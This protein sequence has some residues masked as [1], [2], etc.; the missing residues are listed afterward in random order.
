LTLLRS[1]VKTQAS[2]VCTKLHSNSSSHIRG[3]EAA[4]NTLKKPVKM[5]KNFAA[6]WEVPV[7]ASNS[8]RVTT[9]WSGRGARKYRPAVSSVSFARA[10]VM[11]CFC[12]IVKAMSG[13][14]QTNAMASFRPFGLTSICRVAAL[15]TS[16]AGRPD[17]FAR[18]VSRPSKRMRVDRKA[19]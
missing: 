15:K 12:E 6:R 2:K 9:H 3:W 11:L 13:C 19:V 4:V 18:T 14:L 8:L 5:Q 10:A 7:G 1:K 17:E 16:K